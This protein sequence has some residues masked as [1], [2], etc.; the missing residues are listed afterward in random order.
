[1]TA[2]GGPRFVAAMDGT[3]PVPPNSTL[4][5]QPVPPNRHPYKGVDWATAHQ[6]RS[7]THVHCKTQADLD[8]ILKRNDFLTI[9]NYYPSA[10]W[11]PLSK[12]TENYYRLHHDF[13]VMVKRVRTEGPFDWN[14]IVGQ[15]IKELPPELQKEYPFKEG[16]KI[17]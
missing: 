11:W 14:K 4:N 10:P 7:T 9:S 5:S 6:I 17:F 1:M 12:M 16:G 2:A 3:K 8:V 15:W 13:P